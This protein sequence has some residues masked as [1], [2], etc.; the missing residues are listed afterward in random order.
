MNRKKVLIACEESGV[1]RDQFI[2]AGFDAWSCDLKPGRG[3]FSDKHIQGDVI[4]VM[5]DG[6]WKMMIAHPVCTFLSLAGNKWF[7]P[8]YKERFPNRE[9]DR[10]E[11]VKFFMQFIDA[12][13]DM[14][15]VE[16]PIG[17]MSTRHREPD[18]I[19]QP[20]YFGDPPRKSTC[21][22]LKNLTKLK[23]YAADDMFHQK[24]H[25][26]PEPMVVTSGGNSMGQ[27]YYETSLLPLATGERAAARSIT[28]PG[29]AKAMAQQWGQLL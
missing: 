14:I 29:I 27:W 19:I 8:E 15:A 2:L 3:Q 1:V 17:I 24:T 13:I 28:F 23:H 9:Q 6:S 20:Y 5:N 11:A 16:N 4:P 7:L 10:E 22:W 26:D 12:D 25:V 21:L 18:Q